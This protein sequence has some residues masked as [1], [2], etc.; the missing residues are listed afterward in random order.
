MLK[1]QY[2]GHLML[3]ADSL[4]KTWCWG[5]LRAMEEGGDR[6]WDGW[7]ATST[8]WTK[9]E[10]ILGDSEGQESLVCCRPWGLKETD[11]TERLKNSNNSYRRVFNYLNLFIHFSGFSCVSTAVQPSSDQ[12]LEHF[13]PLQRNC[14]STSHSCP[15]P[16]SWQPLIY[17]VF[18]RI[19]YY[20][21]FMW[22]VIQHAIIYDRLLSFNIMFPRFTH[23]EPCTS[24]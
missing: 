19:A 2:F 18:Y 12:I 1:L 4:E 23:L 5:R 7:M 24:T 20:E 22:T 21:Y 10:K 6:G 11:M 16:S 3:R 17:F 14:T 9:F 13:Q 8:Q 15:T